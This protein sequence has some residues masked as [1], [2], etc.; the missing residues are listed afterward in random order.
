M[1]ILIVTESV[2]FP[3][4]NGRELP[5]ASIFGQL[6]KR[7]T[8]DL[9]VITSKKETELKK[10][11]NIPSS[12]R[13][14][15]FLFAK[16][17]GNFKRLMYSMLTFSHSISSYTYPGNDTKCLLQN[18]F[19]DFVWVSPVTFY[20]FIDFCVKNNIHFFKK[21]AIG[22]ND[23]KTYLYRDYFNEVLY[24][25]IINRKYLIYWLRS[26]LISG[27]EK[28]Y[29][30]K[31]DL[32]H[33]QTNAEAAKVQKLLPELK[34]KIIIAPNGVKSEL[35]GCTYN[36]ADSNYILFMTNLDGDRK[37]ESKWFITK[38]W[39]LI[40]QA[41]PAARLLIAGQP[42]KQPIDYIAN[43]SSII[44]N[45]F[46]DDLTQLYNTVSIAVVA[47]FHGTG[48]INR[49]LDAFTAG[50][51][52]VSTPQA[53][54]T[55]NNIKVEEHILSAQTP[56]LFADQVIKLFNNKSYR[57]AVANAGREYAKGCP[58]WEET[59]IEIE[60]KMQSLLE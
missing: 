58:T 23:S 17:T 31:A 24:T 53:I 36:G 26:F 38:V 29:L 13:N 8:I 46:A 42:P 51:P 56:K 34:R 57:T 1:N 45:G 43:D 3:S 35:F 40:K 25:G 20:T 59:S 47:T 5:I 16:K 52:V 19:Y 21:F 60:S 50:V 48:L 6:S 33:V 14:T 41:L 37:D 44:I 15:D 2:P 4:T 11:R 39:I 32:V 54:A 7:H 9:L 55:F 18:K 27:E 30:Q 49:I 28:N 10:I 12:I 22:L